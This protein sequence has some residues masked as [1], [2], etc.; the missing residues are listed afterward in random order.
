[1]WHNAF[2]ARRVLKELME[3][4]KTSSQSGVY[5][6]ALR[7]ALREVRSFGILIKYG[8]KV[9]SGKTRIKRAR[10]DGGTSL[11]SLSS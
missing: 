1:M 11:P 3:T 10:R 4:K 8:M 2:R 7:I 6:P 9:K 5:I